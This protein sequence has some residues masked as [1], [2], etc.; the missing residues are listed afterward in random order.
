LPACFSR[1]SLIAIDWLAE[2][3]LGFCCARERLCILGALRLW[4]KTLCF[5]HSKAVD[6]GANREQCGQRHQSDK[7]AARP[8]YAIYGGRNNYTGVVRHWRGQ[9]G[10]FL[11]TNGVSGVKHKRFDTNALAQGFLNQCAEEEAAAG[12]QVAVRNNNVATAA[13]AAQPY[14]A[15]ELGQGEER[16]EQ[17]QSNDIDQALR[18]VLASVIRSKTDGGVVEQGQEGW[19][20]QQV[21]TVFGVTPDT[22]ELWKEVNDAFFGQ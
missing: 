18:I 9:G 1:Y 22:P 5:L 17:P 10:A 6:T 21:V 11:L 8:F 19:T 7:L 13:A 2:W 16:Q 4:G 15:G 20:F 12:L 14:S 3:C